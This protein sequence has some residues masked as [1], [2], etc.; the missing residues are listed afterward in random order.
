MTLTSYDVIYIFSELFSTYTLYYFV[1]S[2][3]SIAEKRILWA[4]G[5]YVFYFIVTVGLHFVWNI[6]FLNL[7]FTIA[8]VI[9]VSLCYDTTFS[10]RLLAVSEYIVLGFAVE[11]V[12][13]VVT[14]NA[15]IEPFQKF[16]YEN[17]LGLFISRMIIFL[18]VLLISCFTNRRKQQKLLPAWMMFV[19]PCIPVLTI[20]IE[21]LFT[22]ISGAT[23]QL[24]VISMILLFAINVV[25]F[26]L[27][28]ILAITY[29][30]AMQAATTEQEKIYYQN[31]CKL[32]QDSVEQ[33]R[34]FHHDISNHFMMIQ[35]FLEQGKV[36]EATQYLHEL[37]QREKEKS[38]LYSDTG[39]IVVDSIIN[40][41][42]GSLADHNIG[43]TIDILIPTELPMEITDLSTILTNLLDN[44]VQA[45]QN[46]ER[47]VERK[48]EID[49]NYRK[50]ILFILVK[51]TYQGEVR[52]ENGEIVTTKRDTEKHGYGLKNIVSAA[53]KYDGICQFHHDGDCFNAEV[54]LY[55]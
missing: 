26:F 50:G 32:M 28:D 43:I 48:F 9:L 3:F 31:Q 4:I 30:R 35:N 37:E 41:K 49:M 24:A 38:I 55:L 34:T 21:L 14:K 1:K 6:P 33:A 51:N 18:I 22:S 7:I 17:E 23:V 13:S 46:I 20:S 19:S 27:Y 12:V 44:A 16:E 15:Y 54:M 42:L 10:R 2:I 5:A 29:A 25:M 39:N 53:E 8:S 47:E 11:L 52:Y 40:Y 45:L 36:R